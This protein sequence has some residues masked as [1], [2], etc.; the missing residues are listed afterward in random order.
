MGIE[1]GQRRANKINCIMETYTFRK[2]I[3]NKGCHA[4]ILYD[5]T[6]TND[7]S[8]NLEV[9]CLVAEWEPICK[10]A[11]L[12]FYEYFRGINTGSIKIIIHDVMWYPVDTNSLIVLFACINAFSEGL[13]IKIH[14]LKFDTENEVFCFPEVRSVQ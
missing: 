12:I 5:I 14:N 4:E 6:F 13:D 10:A 2:Q 1:N 11:A 7:T 8:S 9:S 3:G